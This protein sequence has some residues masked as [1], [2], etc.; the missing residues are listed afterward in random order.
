MII[1]GVLID[2]FWIVSFSGVTLYNY[3]TVEN[4]KSLLLSGFFSAIQ[5]FANE[6]GDKSQFIS[7]ITL[8]KSIINFLI[9]NDLKLYFI[10]KSEKKIKEKVIVKH[11]KK[12][13]SL[14][15]SEFKEKVENFDGD[16]GVFE[17]FEKT[18]EAY[19]KD[20]FKELKRLW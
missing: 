14:F 3:S 9:N 16:V 18:F 12:I 1:F 8:G 2:D 17:P 19:F 6:L 10:S 15:L 7:S 13:E 4:K 5:M 20:N 11:L